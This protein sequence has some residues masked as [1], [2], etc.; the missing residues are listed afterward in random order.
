MVDVKTLREFAEEQ[1]DGHDK[2]RGWSHVEVEPWDFIAL[3]DEIE[4]ARGEAKRAHV[5]GMRE[6]LEISGGQLWAANAE[7]RIERRI[8]ELEANQ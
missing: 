4:A 3:L 5:A 8:A 6:A 7:N 2:G 1:I